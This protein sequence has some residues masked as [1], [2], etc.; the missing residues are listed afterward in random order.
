MARFAVQAEELAGVGPERVSRHGTA[1]AKL[2]ESLDDVLA[3]ARPAA[4]A[5]VRAFKELTP[6]EVSVEF[7]LSIDA[8]AGAVFARAGVG[9]HF[10]VNLK[11][12]PEQGR[13]D[14]AATGR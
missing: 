3:S 1:V 7:G 8:E 10:T 9:A 12:A 6:D 5:V 14:G 11:W 13:R 4:E 2:D